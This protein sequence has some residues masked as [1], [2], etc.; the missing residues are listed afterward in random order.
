MDINKKILYG[1]VLVCALAMIIFYNLNATPDYGIRAQDF[2]LKDIE[3]VI[4]TKYPNKEKVT[5]TDSLDIKPFVEEILLAESVEIKNPRNS[6][7]LF[8]VNFFLK[9]KDTRLLGIKNNS[10][11]GKYFWYVNNQYKSEP[12]FNLLD[13][14]RY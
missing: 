6:K 11:E 1:F 5:L 8:Y 4:I 13:S 7:T 9:N 14:T 3:K 2:Q 12:F 10:K